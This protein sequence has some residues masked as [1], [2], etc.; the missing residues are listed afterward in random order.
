MCLNERQ[1]NSTVRMRGEYGT[2]LDDFKYMGSTVHSN[3]NRGGDVKKI[4]YRQDGMVGE[5]WKE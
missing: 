2:K 4:V 1:N 3:G 5:G